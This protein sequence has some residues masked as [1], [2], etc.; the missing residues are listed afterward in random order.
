MKH[1]TFFLAGLLT[2]ALVPGLAFGQGFPQFG[3]PPGAA[4][5][6]LHSPVPPAPPMMGPAPCPPPMFGAP[7]CGPTSCA[8]PL[9]GIAHACYAGYLTSSPGAQLSL[10]SDEVAAAGLVSISYRYPLEGFW[11]GCGTRVPWGEKGQA[12]L[13]GA[14]L[15]PSKGHAREEA[16]FIFGPDLDKRSWVL[17]LQ[18]ANVDLSGAYLVGEGNAAVIGGVRFDSFKSNF[19]DPYDFVRLNPAFFSANR[20][21]TSIVSYV[22]YLGVAVQKSSTEGSFSAGILGFPHLFGNIVYKETFF[23][24]RFE[25]AAPFHGGYFLELFGEANHN[26]GERFSVGAFVRWHAMHGETNTTLDVSVMG[27]PW[28]DIST[29]TYRV[30]FDRQAWIFGGKFAFVF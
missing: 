18:W 30:R 6:A 2:A 10:Q 9:M 29:G 8:K 3:P 13:K 15:F 27:I 25:T 20:A 26:V 28:T 17:D 22:P 19:K 24:Q 23:D 16:A 1:W 21:D 7:T 5:P 14:W 4:G 12:M 11:L